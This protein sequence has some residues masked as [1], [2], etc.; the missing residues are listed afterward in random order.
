VLYGGAAGGG[1]SVG[2]LMGALQ[3]VDCPGYA[4]I[5][6]RRKLTDLSLPGSLMDRANEWLAPTAATYSDARKTWTFPSGAT[7]S[8]GYLDH[9]D[10]KF[11]YQSSEFQFVGFDE[12]TQFPEADYLYLFSRLRQ[13]ATSPIPLRM[14]AATN[15]GGAGHAWVKKRFLSP[16]GQEA[17]R[18][19]IP[20]R[21][22]DNPHLDRE[23]YTRALS[24]LPAFVRKQLE[25]GDWSEFEGTHFKP[26]G[27]PR[28]RVDQGA[29]VLGPRRI[30]PAEHLWSFCT[31]DPATSATGEDHDHTCIMTCGVAP[32]GELLILDVLRQRLDL[33]DIIPAL[34]RTCRTWQPLAFAGIENVAFQ[35]LLV[36]EASRYP[37]LPPIK[38]L[39]PKGK[40]KLERA[41]AAIVKGE[42]GGIYLPEAADWLEDFVLE[43]TSFTGA[44]DPADDQTDAL[45]YAVLAMGQRPTGSGGG[46]V[47]LTPRL[48][49]PVRRRRG[50]GPLLTPGFSEACPYPRPPLP[51]AWPIPGQA[52]DRTGGRYW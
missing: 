45:A 11:R 34:A 37:G 24:N 15:P 35:A 9:S 38:P 44:N 40:G 46:P 2:L 52:D 33:G 27:W 22:T 14:R 30:V 50:P 48:R 7:L 47:L 6:F 36:R 31:L 5:L 23:E 25:E 32:A 18:V 19:F 20:A 39:S 29:Y 16:E 49:F 21:L 1:K 51:T 3:F 26:A 43:L 13:G 42:T 4:A 12:L 28:Y 8:F 41:M 10:D 17:G